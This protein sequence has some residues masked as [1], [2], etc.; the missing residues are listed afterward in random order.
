MA[1]TRNQKPVAETTETTPK[2]KKSGQKK[3]TIAAGRAYIQASYNNT[4]VTITSPDG[5]VL[6]W[7]SSGSS[8]FK[9]TRKATPYAAQVAAENAVNKAKIYGIEKVDVYV[10]GIGS[11]REQALR[12]L[13]SAG[14]QVE[15]ITDTTT[16]PHNGCRPKKQRR[17]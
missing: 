3:L 13:H 16:I 17:V 14:L 8:G 9:G 5:N 6:A 11:G 7:S 2:P 10:K 1:N 12:G 15:R 4:I